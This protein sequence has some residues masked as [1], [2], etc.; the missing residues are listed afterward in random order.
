MAPMK[1]PA[2]PEHHDPFEA[3]HSLT[4]LAHRWNLPRRKIRDLL[5]AGDLPFVDLAGQLRVPDPNLRGVL[6]LFQ[7]S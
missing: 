2:A 6:G 3:S 4:H 7:L 1:R 5:K